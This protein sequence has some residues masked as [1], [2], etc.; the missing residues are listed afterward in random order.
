MSAPLRIAFIQ[1]EFPV[2]TETF[3]LDQVVGL[4][5]RG[6]KV[7]IFATVKD[8]PS[9]VQ[10]S[11]LIHGLY[12]RVQH[13]PNPQR[14]RE[15]LVEGVRRVLPM[16]SCCPAHLFYTLNPMLYRPFNLLLRNPFRL[17]AWLKGPQDFDIV[18]C[19]YGVSGRDFIFLKD[20][21]GSR[22]KFIVSFHGV[23]MSRFLRKGGRDF[24]RDLFR[25]A[26]LFLPVSHYWAERL[27]GLGCPKEKIIVHHMGVDPQR[28]QPKVYPLPRDR[29]RF[30]LLTVGTLREKK[31]IEYALRAL[32][33]IQKEGRDF[34]YRVAGEGP[35]RPYLE[36]LTAR[37]GLS[38]RV[39]FLGP[40]DHS[41]IPRLLQQAD[42]FLLPSVTAADGDQEGIPVVL[43]EAMVAGIPVVSTYHSG[44]PELVQDGRSGLLVAERDVQGLAGK[45]RYLIEQPE[46][47][48]EM[49]RA[50][51][52]HV[53]EHFNLQRQLDQLEQ[54]YLRLRDQI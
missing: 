28:F 29:E 18:H 19:Q 10:S 42:I 34:S 39:D 4:I 24:Y 51:R 32:A 25:K 6:H 33:L 40:V 52:Q 45:L 15:A 3:I 27:Q 14:L 22:I 44:I 46:L 26:D 7:T 41:E 23:D 11:V 50:G 12:Q 16:I 47:M 38:E 2:L 31:G 13:V 21:W 36:D 53:L 30:V 17:W 1:P 5:G 35:L 37:L 54:I 49:A 20:L 8:V 9:K 43:M 48:Q